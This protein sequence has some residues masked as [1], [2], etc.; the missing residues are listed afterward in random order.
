MTFKKNL[1]S[2]RFIPRGP[3]PSIIQALQP[4]TLSAQEIASA[5][6]CTWRRF[7]FF[8]SLVSHHT[9]LGSAS[10]APRH[11][12]FSAGS[13]VWNILAPCLLE[14]QNKGPFLHRAFQNPTTTTNTP[15]VAFPYILP[16]EVV[17]DQTTGG[18]IPAPP[19]IYRILISC[20][21]F[22]SLFPPAKQG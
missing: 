8:S 2:G 5:Q 16:R 3:E 9:P 10:Q 11:A 7:L 15:S 17:E 13:S 6:P 12:I 19:S 21:T 4:E 18:T 22:I 1:I 20:L 14:A